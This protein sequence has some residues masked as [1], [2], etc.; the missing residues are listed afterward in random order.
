[1]VTN[2]QRTVFGVKRLI[3][4]KA[5]APEGRNLARRLTYKLVQAKSGDAWVA[6]AGTP[7]SPQEVSAHVL[8]KMQRVAEDYLG[9]P[10]TAAVVTV[11]A[12]FDD[13]PRHAPKDAGLL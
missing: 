7:R 6:I 3:G 11:P 9:S 2:P 5:T 4:R 1:M 8:A 10:V 13:A 12:Y